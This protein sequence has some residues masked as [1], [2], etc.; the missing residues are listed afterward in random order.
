M[1]Q[2]F[3]YCFV[4]L[5]LMFCTYAQAQLTVRDTGQV[6]QI[7]TAKRLYLQSPDPSTNI[8]TLAGGVQL[9]QGKT[10]FYCDSCSINNNTKIFEAFG[11]VHIN[12]SDTT[13]T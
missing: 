7:I 3:R 4:L 8:Q 6:I 10:L 9:R 11:N 12:D 1:P 13:N 5:L 2:K